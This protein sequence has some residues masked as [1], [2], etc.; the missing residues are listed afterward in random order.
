MQD[1]LAVPTPCAATVPSN[2][3]RSQTRKCILLK[4]VESLGNSNTLAR[5]RLRVCFPVSCGSEDATSTVACLSPSVKLGKRLIWR[6]GKRKLGKYLLPPL[7]RE[8]ERKE[9]S[10]FPSS[11]ERES[12]AEKTVDEVGWPGFSWP[13][14]SAFP[15]V[16]PRKAAWQR[17]LILTQG[18]LH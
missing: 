4:Q 17:E 10:L 16:R 11:N 3:S 7:K 15:L 12:Q 6:K 2:P 9:K 18:S 8:R 5:E 13:P 1:H 14:F